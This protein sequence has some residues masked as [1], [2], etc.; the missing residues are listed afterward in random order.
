MTTYVKECRQEW[1]R[2]GVP[3]LLAEEMAMEL[4]SDLAEAQADGVSVTEILGESDPRRFAANWAS[5]RGLVSEPAPPQKQRRV[6]PWVVAAVVLLFVL[7]ST[8]LALQ[9]AGSS[10]GSS[11]PPVRV[12][13]PQRQ[14]A[15]VRIPDLVGM[16]S[17]QALATARAAGLRNTVVF[18]RGAP[19]G[20]VVAQQPAPGALAPRGSTIKLQIARG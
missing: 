11:G 10:S 5:E 7:F 3:D 16:R 2:L 8:W 9:S 14:H 18:V 17:G 15:R 19:Q 13:P 6:W 12:T 1:K 4:E 20:E